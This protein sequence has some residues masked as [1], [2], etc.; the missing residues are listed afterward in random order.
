VRILQCFSAALSAAGK[1]VKAAVASTDK[2]DAD[3]KF[4]FVVS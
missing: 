3:A 2:E 4:P 1:G